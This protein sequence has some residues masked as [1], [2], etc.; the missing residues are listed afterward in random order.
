MNREK[1]KL[2]GKIRGMIIAAILFMIIAQVIHTLGSYATMSFYTNPEYFHLWSE[3]MMPN[4][5]PPGI[6]FFVLSIIFNFI[7]ALI[8]TIFYVIIKNSVHGKFSFMKG[9]NYGI[10]LFFITA[11]PTFLSMS[12]LLSLPII[13]NISWMIEAL[14]IDI[15][16]GIVIAKFNK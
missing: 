6:E 1:G 3:I 8:F 2:K 15:F 13:L 11:I 10:M 4:M 9:I 5:G 16:G 7:T 14:I 12:L